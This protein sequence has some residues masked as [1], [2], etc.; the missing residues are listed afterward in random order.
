[1]ARSG[2]VVSHWHHAVENFNT[3]TLVFF[4]EIEA[5][6][7][8]K[9]APVRSERVDYR[10]S[11]ILSDK[12]EYL[13]VSYARYSFD[14]AAAPFGKDFFFSWWLVRRLPD[15]S[16]MMG[17]LGMIGVPIAY[18]ILVKIVG[19]FLG[20]L[21]L[22]GIV[23]GLLAAAMNNAGELGM[24]IE[25]AI[26]SLPLIG[27]LYRR[28][29]RPITY[30]SEDSRKMFEETVHR[31]V[32]QHVDGLLSVAKMPPLTPDESKQQTRKAFD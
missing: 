18:F 28:F 8:E 25:D 10:E 11:G 12:R 22:V 15:A 9:L 26:L 7:A 20:F 32:L 24:M 31:I 23:G 6:L 19:V 5:T 1:M 2:E 29:V 14:I 4:K 17:C 16:L 27:A 3:S 30:Y 21:A 13:R